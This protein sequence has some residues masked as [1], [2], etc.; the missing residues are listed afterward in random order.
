LASSASAQAGLEP[1]KL[2]NVVE[3]LMHDKDRSG[4][5][6]FDE[7]M[8]IVFRRY[9]KEALEARTH[10]LFAADQDGD[11][12]ISFAEFQKQMLD[13]AINTSRG[14]R[15]SSGGINMLGMSRLKA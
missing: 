11:N 2:F 1:R 9:G 14:L 15:K 13:I 6:S 8:E 7:A 5:V 3:F 12:E 10:E 4:K